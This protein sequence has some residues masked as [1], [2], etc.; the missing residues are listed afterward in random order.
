MP[1]SAADRCA[2][3]HEYLFHLTKRPRYF[4]AI[5]EI[6][7]PHAEVSLNRAAPHRSN[8]AGQPRGCPYIG[9]GMHPQTFRLDQMNH[10]LGKLPG[11]VWE[12][13]P[14]AGRAGSHRTR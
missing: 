11:S 13:A 7:E 3:R 4:S 9:T 6:R 5:D 10:P 14:A 2:T 8:P 12:I 1:E